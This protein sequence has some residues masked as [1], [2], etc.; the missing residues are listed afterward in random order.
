MREARARAGREPFAQRAGADDRSTA[1]STMLTAG[2]RVL[3]RREPDLPPEPAVVKR[4][5][6]CDSLFV[7][8]DD[9]YLLADVSPSEVTVIESPD[10]DAPPS[11]A[12]APTTETITHAANKAAMGLLAGVPFEAAEYDATVLPTLPTLPDEPRSAAKY[13]FAAAYKE[14]GNGLFKTG[15]HAWA[16]RTYLVGATLLQRL[17]YEDGALLFT[18]TE[19]HAVGVACYSNAA[20]CALKL[21]RHE[22]ASQMCDWGLRFG[23]QGSDRAKL[24]LRKAQAELER[25]KHADPDLAVTLLEQ[26]NAAASSRPVLEMLQRAK[27]AAKQKQKDADRALFSG[28]GF[29]AGLRLASDTAARADAHA[30][31][32]RL[33]R[34]G[35]AAFFGT[36]AE[37]EHVPPEY[38]EALGK[39]EPKVDLPAASEAFAAAVSAATE[40][41]LVGD[42]ATARFAQGSLAAE[43]RET[44]LAID[45]FAAFFGL[46]DQLLRGGGGGG[47]GGPGGGAAA[48]AADDGSAYRE[49]VLGEAHGRFHY[50]LALYTLR[51]AEE[52]T[53]QLEAYLDAVGSFKEI[54]VRTRDAWGNQVNTALDKEMQRQRRWVVCGRCEFTA[55]RML[56][57][58]KEHAAATAGDDAEARETHLRAALAHLEASLALA[59]EPQQKEEAAREIEQAK[60]AIAGASLAITE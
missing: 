51:R 3:A 54:E 45:S 6:S 27:R 14:V 58:L 26:A 55:R 37:R 30:E 5:R 34:S 33:M 13:G 16:L 41:G 19:A 7:R 9:G 18:D 43:S 25:P 4:T 24:L 10:D 21:E 11:S 38:R 44:E 49:P 48:A 57:S 28:K 22:L 29:G 56:A 39:E 31:C 8:F 23:P 15:K 60:R 46:R 2:T 59:W 17:G 35:W 36:G 53:V 50:G 12:A 42:L 47:G 1:P 20:L 52:A 40:A 32:E